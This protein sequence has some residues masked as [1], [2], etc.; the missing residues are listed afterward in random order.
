MTKTEKMTNVKAL[1]FVLENCE[2]PTEIA[3]KITNIHASYVKKSTASAT[4]ERKPTATQVANEA[5]KQAI[6]ADM[7]AETAYRVADILKTFPCV[8]GLTSSKVTAM[9]T[10]LVKAN[11]V[12]R[13]ESKGKAYYTKA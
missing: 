11:A 8:A 2:L 13:T 10:Q 6:L 4:G 5:L 7:K 3:E 9:L 1:A 12:V